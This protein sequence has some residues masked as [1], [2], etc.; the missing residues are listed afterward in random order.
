MH[1]YMYIHA[2][3]DIYIYMPVYMFIQTYI[4]VHVD[5]DTACNLLKFMLCIHMYVYTYTTTYHWHPAPNVPIHTYV[6]R[7]KYTHIYI[8][9]LHKKCDRWPDIFGSMHLRSHTHQYENPTTSTGTCPVQQKCNTLQ[10]TATPMQHTCNKSAK[11]W[12]MQHTW[13]IKTVATHM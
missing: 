2:Y 1:I 13:K 12:H 3:M 6:S 4:Y 9:F 10:H 7:S 5:T 11:S 8:E